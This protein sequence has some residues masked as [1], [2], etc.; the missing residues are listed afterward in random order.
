M[1]KPAYLILVFTFV[2]S[3]VLIVSVPAGAGKGPQIMVTDSQARA[4]PPDVA[5][6]SNGNTHI[7]YSDDTGTNSREIWYTMLDSSGSTLIDDTRLTDDDDYNS[8][9]PGIVIDSSNKVYITFRDQ[10][11]RV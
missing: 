7:V 11:G 9:R 4:D 3:T 2:L 6:A 5:I 1:K 10:G 8:T